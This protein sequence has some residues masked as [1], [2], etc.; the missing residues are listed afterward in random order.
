MH[1]S[2]KKWI[3]HR[4][5]S[6]P[7]T[8]DDYERFQRDMRTDLRRQAKASG[9]EFHAFNKG[10]YGF[11]AVLRNPENNRFI[12]VSIPD[13]RYWQDQW[14]NHVLYR[15][16]EHERDWTGGGNHL[17]NWEEIG[18]AAMELS[19]RMKAAC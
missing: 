18:Q 4:F 17:G 13:V 3:G 14:S 6:G 19:D 7:E 16:M 5:S 2:L 12:Y 1:N 8:G 15:T 11:S 10:H 9:L